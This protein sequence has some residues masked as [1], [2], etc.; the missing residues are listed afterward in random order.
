MRLPKKEID[1]FVRRHLKKREMYLR[2]L[3]R[4]TSPLYIIEPDVLRDRARQFSRAFSEKFADCR[5][6][7]A[8]KSNNHP[9]VS[10]TV[11]EEGFGLD[12][13][14][15]KELEM[16][17]GLGAG[18]ILFTGPGK[19]G[20]ELVLAVENAGKV[21]ILMDSFH[22]FQALEE[23]AAARKVSVRAGVRLCTNATGLWRKFGILLD[24]L[25]GFFEAADRCPH[26]D[27]QG[28]QFHTSWNLSPQAQSDFIGLLGKKLAACPASILKKIR[29]VDIGGGYWPQ[30]GE[31]LRAEPLVHDHRPAAAIETFAEELNRAVENHLGFLLPGRIYIEP[32]RWIC[33]DAMHLMMTV[34]DKKAPDLVITDAGINAIGWERFETDYFPILNLT[35]PSLQEKP[36][37]ICGSLC[38]P[39][40]NFGFS[41]FG[42]EIG[43]G[44]VLF[45]PCQGA[46]TYSLKQDFIKPAP[47]V[48]ILDKG[49]KDSG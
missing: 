35:R 5:C 14:S 45:V 46:Y 6:Y 41:Y 9:V 26:V 27:L 13:A 49:V 8:V 44:D 43:S 21:T 37:N 4:E 29:F 40:D 48:V 11:L 2:L 20:S 28:L 22:E 15:G 19:T 32:G 17:L 31:W 25:P 36:C 18:D 42:E 1:R 33:N 39:A 30:P 38:T 47:R 24:D 34:V 12:I 3:D 23:I 16:A 10:R 7:F